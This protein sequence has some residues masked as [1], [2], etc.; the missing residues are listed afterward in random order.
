[1][2]DARRVSLCQSI[3][4]LPQIFEDGYQIYLLIMNFLAQC[5]PFDKLHRN[6]IDPVT[7]TNFIDV[8][9]VRVVQGGRRLRF[10]HKA[11]H[12]ALT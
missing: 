2:H 3:S 12:S 1:M 6:K 5:R 7:L 11:V 10:L 8:R 4:N 9:D